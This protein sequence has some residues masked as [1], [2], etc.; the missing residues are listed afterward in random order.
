V[1]SKGFSW[2]G[3]LCLDDIYWMEFQGSVWIHILREPTCE[4]V[5]STQHTIDINCIFTHLKGTSFLF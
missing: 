4:N 1:I 3:H 5:T 2:D